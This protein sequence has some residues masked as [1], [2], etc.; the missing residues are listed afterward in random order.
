MK[1]MFIDFNSFFASCEQASRPELR[2]RAVVV[3]PLLAETT[4]CIAASRE[5]KAFGIKTG[6]PVREARRLCLELEVVEARPEPYIRYQQALNGVIRD[7]GLDPHAES[8]DEV[9]C[10]L[11]GEWMEEEAARELAREIKRQL[12]A[13]VSPVLTCSIGVAPNRFLAKTAS[14]MEKPD[15]LVVIRPED[16]PDRLH[17][18]E[19]RDLCGIGRHMELRLRAHAIQSVAELCAASRGRLRDIWGS[20][21]GAFFHDAL[22]GLD[23]P[24]RRAE[25]Q[26]TLGH[27]HI[28]PP[29][30]RTEKGAR[31][32]LHR[33]AQKA[34]TRLRREGGVTARMSIFVRYLGE[35]ANWSD[36]VRFNPTQDVLELLRT[37]ELLWAR[38]RTG[39]RAV[40]FA[41]G[42][43]F[44]ELHAEENCGRPLFER[45]RDERRRALMAAVDRLNV[46]EG[47]HTVYLGGAH[48]AVDYSPLRIAFHRI[49]DPETEG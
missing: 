33:L 1:F 49:P 22:H 12:A 32:V 35:Q 34:A 19:L 36:E 29:E 7:C 24:R 48:G 16:L 47:K 2:G 6:T 9:H 10:E 13:R 42:V 37:L 43:N 38:R 40:P 8:I 31:S 27:S 4:C 39:R 46:K 5:A 28:L 25:E 15:G 30:L 3:V 23:A 11:W 21:E 44:L 14:D 17:R 45:E 18:L 26:R 41:V 20:V